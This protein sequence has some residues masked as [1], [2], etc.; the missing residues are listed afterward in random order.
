MAEEMICWV[1][2][3]RFSRKDRWRLTPSNLWPTRRSAI[4][5]HEDITSSDWRTQYRRGLVR[6]I[7]VR[8]VPV[9]GGKDG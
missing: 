1:V 5:D 3:F 6:C 9:N 7:K 4:E 8:V 2:K